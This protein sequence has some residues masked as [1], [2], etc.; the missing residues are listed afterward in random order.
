M[1]ALRNLKAY[2]PESR[3]VN[4]QAAS[5]RDKPWLRIRASRLRAQAAGMFFKFKISLKIE[6]TN[7]LLAVIRERA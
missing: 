4:S 6:F 2:L 5:S 7:S 1:V 3:A